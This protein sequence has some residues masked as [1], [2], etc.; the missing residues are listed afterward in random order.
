VWSWTGSELIAWGRESL[1]TNVTRPPAGTRTSVGDTPEDVI[2]I[3]VP[4]DGDDGVDPPHA[5]M[6]PS[7]VATANLE[8]ERTTAAFTLED[9]TS[10]SSPYDVTQ[11]GTLDAMD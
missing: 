7:P 5:V 1:L 4:V 9:Y 8:N 2:V 6:R 3:V 11:E 10:C